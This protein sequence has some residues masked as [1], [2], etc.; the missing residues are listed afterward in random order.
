MSTTE[1]EPRKERKKE[2][3][4][5]ISTKWGLTDSRS[6][7]TQLHN[8]KR[9]SK[10]DRMKTKTMIQAGYGPLKARIPKLQSSA[11]RMSSVGGLFL[12]NR[13]RFVFE[14]LNPK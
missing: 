5:N 7:S 2:R 11:S 13:M 3:K 8:H 9:K 10:S 6:Q 14:S 1:A 4:K 12:R